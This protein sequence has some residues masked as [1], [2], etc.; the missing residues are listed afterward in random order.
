[1]KRKAKEQEQLASGF[2][3]VILALP[4][5]E[6]VDEFAFVGEEP[7]GKNDMDIEQSESTKARKKARQGV[8]GEGRASTLSNRQRMQVL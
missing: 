8:I 3:D 5:A 6:E 1:M 4:D 7:R 2:S